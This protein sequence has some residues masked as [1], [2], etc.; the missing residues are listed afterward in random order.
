MP[1]K[2]WFSE[3]LNYFDFVHERLSDWWRSEWV[4]FQNLMNLHEIVPNNIN[5][6]EY[7]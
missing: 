1:Q 6:Y 7:E 5:R 3:K 4:W 2:H